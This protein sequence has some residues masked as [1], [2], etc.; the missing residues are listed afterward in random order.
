[1]TIKSPIITPRAVKGWVNHSS[2]LGSNN[3]DLN[4]LYSP[5]NAYSQS[6]VLDLASPKYNPHS[7]TIFDKSGKNNHGTITGAT[8]ERLPSGQPVLS[9]DGTDDEVTCGD[10]ASLYPARLTVMCWMNIIAFGGAASYLPVIHK[11]AHVNWSAPYEDYS[12]RYNPPADIIFSSSNA[13]HTSVDD[14]IYSGAVI[15]QWYFVVGTH[16]GSN[17]ILYVDTVL[18]HS[19][20]NVGD[21]HQGAFPLYIGHNALLGNFGN[22][23]VALVRVLNT[24]LSAT[25]IAGTFNQERHLFNG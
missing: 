15:N 5:D 18:R 10:N 25:Q 3:Y 24:A 17:S 19:S 16:D 20:V 7:T 6:C 2:V 22:F 11:Q 14:M 4:N 23:K 9:F 8:W 12:I 13:D 21:L 1:M